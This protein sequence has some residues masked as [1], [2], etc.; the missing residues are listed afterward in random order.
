MSLKWTAKTMM[1]KRTVLFKDTGVYVLPEYT[2]GA[3]GKV[4]QTHTKLCSEIL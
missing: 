2:D 1:L 3:F 4:I